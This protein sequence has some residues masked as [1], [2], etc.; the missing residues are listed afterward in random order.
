MKNG[1]N[2]V[3][4][5]RRAVK[6]VNIISCAAVFAVML[7][8]DFS[9]PFLSDDYHF[10]YVWEGIKVAPGASYRRISSLKDVLTSVDNYYHLSGGRA[11]CHFFTFSFIA[12]GKPVFNVVNSLMFCWLGYML[13]KL[14]GGK[15]RRES[16]ILPLVYGGL[17]FL[18]P[19]FG[20]NTLWVSGSINY[21]WPSVL[22]AGTLMLMDRFFKA[23]S[24]KTGAAA[25][26]P[27]AVCSLT[28]EMTGGM[29]YVY[30][31]I[32]AIY[33]LSRKGLRKGHLWLL[34]VL[35]ICA[36]GAYTVLAAPGNSVRAED[37]THTN[38]L[39]L[40]VIIDY[41]FQYMLYIL[42]RER[43]A[44]IAVGLCLLRPKKGGGMLS[45]GAKRLWEHR[46]FFTGLAGVLALAVTGT[47]TIRPMYIG[48][49]LMI[50]ELCGI[51][52][53]GLRELGRRRA[54][55]GAHGTLIRFFAVTAGLELMMIPG[56]PTHI[57]QSTEAAVI[58]IS[59][60]LL[61]A[62]LIAYY[63]RSGK[64]EKPGRSAFRAR[65]V[66]A[67]ALTAV[68][69]SGLGIY[70]AVSCAMF[71]SDARVFRDY[72]SVR[73]ERLLAGEENWYFM[74]PELGARSILF[75]RQSVRHIV[76]QPTNVEWWAY[77]SGVNY[78]FTE[79]DRYFGR[80]LYNEI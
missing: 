62:L 49:V 78:I 6:R 5:R 17:F 66:T 36:A 27:M 15:S 46:V 79:Q 73:E 59:L 69:V 61:A 37:F 31:A 44:F 55:R 13:Y 68:T 47:Y 52:A 23:P 34:P 22:L 43:L 63:K 26:L 65:R 48:A 3:I 58:E 45:C 24:V 60:A 14:I 50:A 30:A 54:F 67:S 75:P 10:H 2:S 4:K 53:K 40:S 70:L 39:T 33:L 1:E 19:M 56:A 74:K 25:L 28:N 18:T 76:T 16:F 7:F 11:L 38:T 29:L 72:L 64:A 35:V 21:V 12:L 20:D 57:S 41:L 32:W 71:A 8:L 42:G 51:F 80:I 77:Y 9:C